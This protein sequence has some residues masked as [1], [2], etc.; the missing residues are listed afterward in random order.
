[1]AAFSR[2]NIDVNPFTA[3]ALEKTNNDSENAPQYDDACAVIQWQSSNYP[4]LSF[5]PQKFVIQYNMIG[6]LM[7]VHPF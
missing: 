5:F 2:I 7:L 6:S 1:L 4:I 3:L